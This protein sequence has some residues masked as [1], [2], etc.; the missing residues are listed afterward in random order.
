MKVNHQKSK[1]RYYEPAV[2]PRLSHGI[3]CQ[4][5]REIPPRWIT[6]YTCGTARMERRSAKASWVIPTTGGRTSAEN[7]PWKVKRRRLVKYRSTRTDNSEFKRCTILSGSNLT[8]ATRSRPG[9]RSNTNTSYASM[10]WTPQPDRFSEDRAAPSLR[11]IRKWAAR[12][13]ESSAG[14]TPVPRTPPLTKAAVG[15]LC[16]PWRSGGRRPAADFITRVHESDAWVELDFASRAEA[17]E[18]KWEHLGGA[19]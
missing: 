11:N 6:W 15:C 14:I 2:F 16:L 18:W 10:D 5:R 7:S 12:F 9:M 8:K 3:V 1:S 13:A 4:S 19:Y 17:K